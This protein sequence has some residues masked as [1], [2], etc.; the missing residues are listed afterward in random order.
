M[1]D[2]IAIDVRNVSVRYL[3]PHENV[4]TFKEFAIRWLKGRVVW[5]EFEALSNVSF[6]VRAGDSVGVIGRNGAGKTTLLKVIARVLRPRS[7]TARTRGRVVPL[8]ELGTGFDAELSGR[9]NV[10]LNGAMLGRSHRYM[11]RRFPEIVAFAGL[12]EFIDAPLRTYSTGMAARLGFAIAT[13][14]DP[15]VLLIDE[16]LAVGD[17]EF[18]Q[19]CAER[20]NRFRER[21][22]TF[23][24][25]SHALENITALCQRALWIEEGRL[26]ADGPAAE[27]VAAFAA[28]AGA[29]PPPTAA[30]PGAGPVETAPRQVSA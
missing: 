11:A 1:D 17:V 5:R 22:A 29:A 4:P 6:T 12:E 2:G 16:V 9:E 27:V 14:V 23:V 10:F 15:D 25:V 26:Q 24:L 7:G 20:I 30:A 18:Q 8:L 21:G 28:A 3:V 19:R 13:D